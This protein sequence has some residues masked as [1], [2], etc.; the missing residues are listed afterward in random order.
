MLEFSVSGS[1]Y[2]VIRVNNTIILGGNDRR[3]VKYYKITGEYSEALAELVGF[4]PKLPNRASDP[5][6]ETPP[7]AYYFL[8]F[9]IDQLRSW[10]SPW[11]SFNNLG[12]YA[13]WKQTIVKYH[14]GYLLHDYFDIEEVLFEYRDQKR[15]ADDE[16]RLI[17]SALDIVEKYV[18][19]NFLA[20]SSE[21]FEEITKEV[22]TELGELASKQESVLNELTRCQSSRYHLYNQ[23]DIAK[24]SISEIEHDYKFSVEYVDGDEIEC[25]L[26]GT[27]HD[28]SLISRANILVD[29][30]QAEDQAS[31]LQEDI[32][33]IEGKISILQDEIDEIRSCISIINTKYQVSNEDTGKE[34]R[35]L[36][37]IVDGF[38]S[39]SVQ[40][41]VEETK[42]QKES[43]SK[44]ISDIQNELKKE[45]SKILSKK[46][47]KELGDMF[48][49]NLTE[50]VNKLNAKG[51]N[52]NKVK[53]PTDYN[54]IFGSGGAAEG[55]RAALAYQMAIFRQI[56]AVANE[57][58]APLV[59][60]TPNQ[61]E[62]ADLHY[63]KIIDLIMNDSPSSSQIIL[64][65]MANPHLEPYA[66][67]AHVIVLNEN[68]LLG[69][70]FYIKLEA[71]VSSIFSSAISE[72]EY[73]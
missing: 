28:N 41:N 47:K 34:E 42:V 17:N 15:E 57:V 45:Q 70:E 61:Q 72:P 3:Y 27:L 22:E 23:L 31:A 60:D 58:P 38:A 69:K 7:P 59:V 43:L 56:Y 53:H 10:V 9:Y 29:Q 37:S 21:E 11:N 46:D 6:L 30:Q 36:S 4:S 48:L 5:E 19:K 68:K 64:C 25:P 40:R 32:N 33:E 24:R 49:G 16:V 1:N 63:E 65:G 8:P 39:R 67:E 66:K 20:I 71:E 44:N 55:T 51:V 18:P 14:T 73:F 13:N 35:S 50:F 2:V 52:L 12:Q 26:C 62:Q 54:K